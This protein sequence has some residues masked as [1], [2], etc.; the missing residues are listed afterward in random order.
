MR[1]V[2]NE[3][4]RNRNAFGVARWVKNILAIVG[5]TTAVTVACFAW[6]YFL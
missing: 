4:D 6:G 1:Y 3:Y 5:L 2:S